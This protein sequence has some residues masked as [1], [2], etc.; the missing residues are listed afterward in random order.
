MLG[1]NDAIKFCCFKTNIAQQCFDQVWS[2]KLIGICYVVVQIVEFRKGTKIHDWMVEKWFQAPPPCEE[3]QNFKN[4][5]NLCGQS[6]ELMNGSKFSTWIPL[7]SAPDQMSKLH[8]QEGL[9][10]SKLD[11]ITF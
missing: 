6:F 7:K 8:L 4:V 5:V 11:L 3:S 9:R 2:Q 1:A 10:F